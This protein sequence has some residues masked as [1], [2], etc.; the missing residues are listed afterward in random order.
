M[1]E[2]GNANSLR[3]AAPCD[4]YIWEESSLERLWTVQWASGVQK[5]QYFDKS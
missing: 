2:L 5:H 3:L 1:K 4:E